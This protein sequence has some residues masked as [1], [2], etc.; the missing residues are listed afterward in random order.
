M[1]KIKDGDYVILITDTKEFIC[2]GIIGDWSNSM[3][4]FCTV[5]GIG[6]DLATEGGIIDIVLK[7]KKP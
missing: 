3:E 1:K 6:Y 7:I 4:P 5:D 2:E